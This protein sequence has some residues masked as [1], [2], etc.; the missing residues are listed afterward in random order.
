M[1]DHPRDASL[2]FIQLASCQMLM[3]FLGTALPYIEV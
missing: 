3:Q 2:C 1:L